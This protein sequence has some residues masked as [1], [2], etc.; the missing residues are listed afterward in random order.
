MKPTELRQLIRESI[1]EYI[2]EIDAAGNKAALDAKMTATQEAIDLRERK[3][4]MD[5]LDEAYHDM[6]DKSKMKELGGEVKALKKSLDKLKKQLDKLN[7]KGTKTEKPEEKEEIVDEAFPES[8][9]QLEED[10]LSGMVDDAEASMGDIDEMDIHEIL[11]MQKLAGIISETEY[12]DKVEKAKK[13]TKK[14][15]SVSKK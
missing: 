14:A 15:K 13:M 10:D 3:M 8:G 1:N 5:G 12:V 6:L 2:S 7:S 11:H 4:N 9:S